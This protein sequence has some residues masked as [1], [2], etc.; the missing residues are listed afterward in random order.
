MA[1]AKVSVIQEEA[2]STPEGARVLVQSMNKEV[3]FLKR[4]VVKTQNEL[5]GWR[6]K[7]HNADKSNGVLSSKLE[8]FVGI[9]VIKYLLS[10]IGTSYGVNLVTSSNQNGWYL[11]VGSA[12]FYILITLWQKR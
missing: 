9:E 3:N 8:F 1:S 6:A 11:V 12:L 10:A 2:L 4:T 7:Y 5:E